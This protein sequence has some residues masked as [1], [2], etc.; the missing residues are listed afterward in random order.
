MLCLLMG[1]GGF[2]GLG[3]QPDPLC[4]AGEGKRKNCERYQ[5]GCKGLPLVKHRQVGVGRGFL[6]LEVS[7][8]W[9]A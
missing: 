4:E 8:D 9:E 7:G 1:E 6:H 2:L 3:E 5:V